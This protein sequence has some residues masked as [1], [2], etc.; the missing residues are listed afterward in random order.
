[1]DWYYYV[2]LAVIP[3]IAGFAGGIVR[4]AAKVAQEHIEDNQLLKALF[5]RLADEEDILTPK[6][7]KEMMDSLKREFGESKQAWVELWKGI[8]ALLESAKK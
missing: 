1:M 3:A 7:F 8:K 6:E 4:K 2:L 5:E